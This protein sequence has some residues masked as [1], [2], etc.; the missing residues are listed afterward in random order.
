MSLGGLVLGV[1]EHDIRPAGASI[2]G[3]TGL[4]RCLARQD[5]VLAITFDVVHGFGASRGH[6][7]LLGGLDEI[8]RLYQPLGFL[9]RRSRVPLGQQL[10]HHHHRD[11]GQNHGCDRKSQNHLFIQS[12]RHV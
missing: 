10:D 5:H 6:L 12:I 8:T 9:H 2:D 3:R 4:E 1:V 7:V 11:R